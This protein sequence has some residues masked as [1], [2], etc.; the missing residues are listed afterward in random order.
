MI[1]KVIGYF[2][3]VISFVAWAVIGVLPFLNL[4]IEMS[5]AITTVLIV[6]GEIAFFLSIVLLGKEFLE[7]FKNFLRKFF[8]KKQDL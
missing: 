5:A 7:K 6:G 2:L 1:K 3:F 8:T 4:S